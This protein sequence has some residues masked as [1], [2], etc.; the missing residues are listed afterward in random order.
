MKLS[1]HV[2]LFGKK[3]EVYISYLMLF[4]I[5]AVAAYL[6]FMN[7]PLRYGFDFD[8]TRDALIV[9]QGAKHLTFPLIG[10]KSG[11]GPFAFGPWYYYELILFKLV[12]PNP[13]SPW[14]F[15][16][17]MSVVTVGIMYL[18]GKELEGKWFGLLLALLTAFS[19]EQIGPVDG[20]SNPNLIPLH[21]AITVLLFIYYI[22]NQNRRWYVWMLWGL[23][24]GI[25][26]NHHYQMILLAPL[27]VLA[28]LY[29][30]NKRAIG[31]SLLF[32]GGLATSFIP[33]FIYNIQNHWKTL[34]GS[35]F[36]L[37]TSHNATYIPN[38]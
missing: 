33:L 23:M 29:K 5:L 2:A 24:F 31:D 17:M 34:T 22:K 16:G 21:T 15:I 12:F 25:G 27:P 37:T 30:R 3:Y 20:L 14:I 32:L 8:P 35:L 18:I 19:P 7:F 36:Y 4:V 38:R 9:A 28:F 10:P 13:F 26:I 11:I 6:R 1:R